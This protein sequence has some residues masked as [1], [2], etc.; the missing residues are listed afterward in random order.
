MTTVSTTLLPPE[1]PKKLGG[2]H[3]PVSESARAL[4]FRLHSIRKHFG[5]VNAKALDLWVH[6]HKREY[7][8]FVQASDQTFVFHKR[9]REV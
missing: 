3:N 8:T 4:S 5:D 9:S 2:S 7:D 6:Q 1:I